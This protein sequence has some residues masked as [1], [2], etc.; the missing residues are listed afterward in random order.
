MERHR[1]E[2]MKLIYSAERFI[3]NKIYHTDNQE[4]LTDFTKLVEFVK[5]SINGE[6]K[7]YWDSQ[8]I[9]KTK[10]AQ[11]VVGEDFDKRIMQGNKDALVLVYHPVKEKNRELIEKFE[12]FVRT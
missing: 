9:P 2:T 5:S 12:E 1:K 11:K 10:Y 8:N 4:T 6:V 3:M 7:Y